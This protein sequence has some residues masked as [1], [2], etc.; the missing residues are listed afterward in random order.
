INYRNATRDKVNIPDI[1]KIDRSHF[2]F[3]KNFD[4]SD[5]Q[6]LMIYSFSEFQDSIFK[7]EILAIPTIGER[8]IPSWL[9]EVKGILSNLVGFDEGQYHDVLVANAYSRQLKEESRTLSA[10]QKE[11]IAKYWQDR[12]IVKLLIRNKE[13]VTAH[14]TFRSATV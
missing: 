13:N 2:R 1:Q 5:S 7:N 11:N 9:N 14:E 12:E 3:L 4:L 8:D 6:Y 10:K